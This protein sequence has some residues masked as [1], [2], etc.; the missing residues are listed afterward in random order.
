VH[1]ERHAGLKQN[2]YAGICLPRKVDLRKLVILFVNSNALKKLG[3]SSLH[4][5]CK[6]SN[7]INQSNGLDDLKA[8][9]GFGDDTTP[10][11]CFLF[12]GL[13]ERCQLS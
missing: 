7:W 12:N 6:Q 5:A 1:V 11:L 2:W 10:Q 3:Q 9:V 8:E 4:L 13:N